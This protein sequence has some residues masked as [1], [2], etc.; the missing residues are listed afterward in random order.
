[1]KKNNKKNKLDANIFSTL[2]AA[3]KYL[4]DSGNVKVAGELQNRVFKS[5]SYEEALT[6]IREYVNIV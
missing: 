4:R 2:A 1:M 6:I 3:T 5:K